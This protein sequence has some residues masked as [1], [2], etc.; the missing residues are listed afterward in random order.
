[1]LSDSKAKLFY[2]NCSYFHVFIFKKLRLGLSKKMPLFV[3]FLRKFLLKLTKTTF[4]FQI[5][6]FQLTTVSVSES[7]AVIALRVSTKAP[8]NASK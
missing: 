7:L 6:Q 5:I 8:P 2:I 3:R 1:M 4:G